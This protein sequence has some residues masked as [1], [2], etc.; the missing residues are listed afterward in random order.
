MSNR[1]KTSVLPHCLR[2]PNELHCCSRASTIVVMPDEVDK[3]VQR[4]GRSDLLK[5]E[6]ST[7]FTIVKIP[8]EPCPFLSQDRLCSIYDI[9]PRDCRSWPLTFNREANGYVLDMGCPAAQRG[10]LSEQFLTASRVVLSSIE[11]PLRHT[12]VELV[13]RDGL[14]LVAI[15]QAEE[16][17]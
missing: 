12:F 3:I 8:G 13:H 7:L 5:A 16:A 11:S 1:D 14:P 10:C 15:E 2:C 17:P 9:R 6:T 4:T